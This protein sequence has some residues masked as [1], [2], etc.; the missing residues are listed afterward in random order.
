MIAVDTNV[1]VRLLAQD[2]PEQEERA[3]QVMK[4]DGVFIAKTVLLET[5]WVLRHAYGFDGIVVLE[6]FKKLLGLPNVTV[7]D[8]Q[9]VFQAIEWVE[10]GMDF[11]DALHLASSMKAGKF[12]TFDRKFSNKA[13][14][15]TTVEIS[16]P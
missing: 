6:A 15:L 4:S 14:Q 10:S 7:E 3:A 12:I 13:T 1:I 2:D 16:T 5:Q 8:P 9:A 11:A